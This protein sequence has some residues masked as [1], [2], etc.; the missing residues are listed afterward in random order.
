MSCS[1]SDDFWPESTAC[2]INTAIRRVCLYFLLV[3]SSCNVLLA[4]KKFNDQRPI[5]KWPLTRPQRASL[6]VGL[7][8]A[9]VAGSVGILLGYNCRVLGCLSSVLV[10]ALSVWWG[11]LSH[12]LR[13]TDVL[14]IALRSQGVSSLR[15]HK[16]M[17]GLKNLVVIASC[18]G[19]GIWLI[20]S[21]GVF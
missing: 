21:L 6:L 10:T 9:S 3:C 13:L 11:C 20:C 12:A 5:H 14:V 15:Y 16:W 19:A 8:Y 2:A 4:I 1:V 18:G 7:H 17:Q